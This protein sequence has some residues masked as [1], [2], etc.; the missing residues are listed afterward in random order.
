M[1]PTSSL[2]IP[3]RPGQERPAAAGPGGQRHP[4]DRPVAGGPVPRPVR[5]R[6]AQGPGPGR[7]GHHRV[8]A[9]APP[10]RLGPAGRRHQAQPV[11]RLAHRGAQGHRRAAGGPERGPAPGHGGGPCRRQLGADPRPAVRPGA[12]A[13]RRREPGR[14]PSIAPSGTAARVKVTGGAAGISFD[15][16]SYKAVAGEA[17]WKTSDFEQATDRYDIAFAKGVRDVVVDTLEPR[18]PPRPA[19]C[20]PRS[21]SPTSSGRPSGPRRPATSGGG[22]CWTPTTRRPGG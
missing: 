15:D 5:G 22:S 7:A 8:R 19:G 18:P 3:A 6:A 13:V 11:G 16:Q 9:P 1:T 14:S 17:T 20:W 4:R 2:G 21:C 10:R 12:A